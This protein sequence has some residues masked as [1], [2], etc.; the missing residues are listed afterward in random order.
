[1]LL[2]LPWKLTGLILLKEVKGPLS[3]AKWYNFKY[4]ITCRNYDPILAKSHKSRKISRLLDYNIF[5]HR[6]DA[7]LCISFS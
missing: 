4:L 2:F 7:G 3:I 5:P 6:N 1:M